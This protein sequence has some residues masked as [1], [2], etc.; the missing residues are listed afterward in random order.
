MGNDTGQGIA[1]DAS[2]NIWIAGSTSSYD[3]PVTPGGFQNTLHGATNA[4]AAEFSNDGKL[5]AA[6]YLGGSNMD[7]GLGIAIGPQ[8]N[9]WLIGVWNSADFPFTTGPPATVPN[10]AV[11]FLAEFDPTAAQLLY[12]A[13]VGGT[14]D[15]N[16][17][18]I[19]I[20]SS[21]NITLVGSTYGAFPVTPGAFHGGNGSQY[22][23]KAFVLKLTQSGQVLYSTFFG[24]TEAAPTPQSYEPEHDYGVAVAVDEAGDAY[25]TGY[26]SAADFPVTPGA[27]QT[28]FA[29]GCP[30]PAFSIDTGFI[31]TINEW[32]V[33]DVFV[34]KLSPDGTSALFST[35]LGGSCYDRATSIALDASGRVY[36]A[37]ETDSGDFPLVDE[38]E[39]PP[40]TGQF[41]SFLSVLNPAGSALTFSTYLYAGS[42]PSVVAPPGRLTLVAGRTGVGAQTQSFSGFVDPFPVTATDG[43]LVLLKPLVPRVGRRLPP[44]H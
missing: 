30:Y 40:P 11:G 25:V 36:V 29:A 35:L 13:N 8:G 2:G 24:G 4:F 9:P 17:K 32:Y 42:G 43:Y 38:V 19:A 14:F 10:P 28:S 6:T 41:I 3:L 21:G 20:D 5:L 1:L 37:G 27:Y 16:G 34:V 26:T 33:D 22:S 44:R 23:P 15:A 39:G 31:G 18:G 12:S 7:G